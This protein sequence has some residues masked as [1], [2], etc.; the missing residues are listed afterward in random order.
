MTRRSWLAVTAGT[1]GLSIMAAAPQAALS[2][3]SLCGA[4]REASAFARAHWDGDIITIMARRTV[5]IGIVATV[6]GPI[7]A[8]MGDRVQAT[9]TT[10]RPI[11]PLW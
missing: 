1:L 7:A 10:E 3:G 5:T 4:T 9:A 6:F 2:G 11:S 8:T